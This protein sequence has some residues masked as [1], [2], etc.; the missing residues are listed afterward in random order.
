MNSDRWLLPEG[1]EELLPQ[2]A[3]RLES[4]RRRLLDLF[5]TWGY[6]LVIPPF[7]E[8]VESLLTGVGKDLDVHTFK[9][10][11]QHNGRT[12]GVRADITPQVARIDAHRLNRDEP[13]R[14]CYIGTVLRTQSDEFASSRSLLQLGAELYGH[15]GIESDCE[16]LCL[17]VDTL[18]NAGLNDIFVDIGHVGVFQGLAQQAGLNQEHKQ[19]LFDALQRKAVPEIRD[20]LAPLSLDDN[21]RQMLMDLALLNG[22]D[23]VLDLAKTKLSHAHASVHQAIEQIREV[24]K[25]VQNRYPNTPLHIDLAEV[26]GIQY[27]TGMVFAAYQPGVGQAIALGGRYDDIGKVFGRARPATGFSAD[28]GTIMKLSDSEARVKNAI[29]AP[30]DENADLT[31]KISQLRA[32]GQRVIVQLPG[33]KGSAKEMGCNK[34]LVLQGGQWVVEQITN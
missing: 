13:T 17:M 16:M 29:F 3:Q 5:H 23:G 28:L 27:H 19:F 6:E 8:Y 9:L 22:N 10:I 32:N 31:K 4:T 1:I 15:S 30:V 18:S 14:L 12:M 11:D 26:R 7:V 24:A 34:Q 21:I 20:F 33:Q 25:R 2:E